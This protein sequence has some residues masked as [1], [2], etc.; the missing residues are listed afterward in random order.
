MSAKLPSADGPWIDGALRW[1]G[2][3]PRAFRALLHAYLLIDFR[4]QQFGRATLSGPKA[5][6]A[7]MFWVVG[8]NLL[9]GFATGVILY[10]RVDVFFFA[11]ANLAVS[12]LVMATAVI[13]EFNEVVLDPEDLEVVGHLPVPARTY[14]AARATNL[15][16]Y[17]LLITVS[18]NLCPAIIGIGLPD[19]GWAFVPAYLLASLA[20][21]LLVVG[22]LI[23][24]YLVLLGD[25]PTESTR[26]LLAWSQIV[27][28]WIA[29]M[30][31]QFVLL[32]DR[33]FRIEML[34]YELPDWVRWLPPGWLAWFVAS[35]GPVGDA[36]AWWVPGV[37]AVATLG[38]WVVVMA[39]LSAAY[40]QMQPGA[41]A[42]RRAVLRPLPRPGDLAGP[43]VRRL[44]RAG[45][46]RVAYWLCTAMLRRDYQL[47][48]RS[49]PAF[50]VALAAVVLGLATGQLG[51]PMKEHS[52][53]CVLSLA[54]LY[55]LTVPVPTILYN[56]NFSR[57]HQASWVLLSAPIGD[58]VAF[59]EGMRKAVTYGVVLPV[60]V[61]LGIVFAVCWRDPLDAAENV[62]AGW[63][64]ILAA[65]HASQIGV[66]RGL[67]F[68]APAA[69]GETMGPIAM[70]A[71]LV[72]GTAMSLVGLH[73]LASQRFWTFAAYLGGLAV[74]VLAL[75][76]AA[77]RVLEQHFVTEAPGHD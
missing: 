71:A 42:W 73:Y 64:A 57:D 1:A 69:R 21:N 20:G 24:V 6:V 68:A 35:T 74:A 77:S 51:D 76:A 13:V 30:G 37:V 39:R 17:V 65:G 56:L 8:Q 61:G 45:E 18:L 44:T 27:L 62:L 49:W 4:N 63:L 26:E 53:V 15:I 47:R 14:S 10:E 2:I 31:G 46:E 11:L 58:R 72:S 54:A 41:P 19:A 67:P 43:I 59:A 9:L 16:G 29:L 33:S 55:L 22:A 25:R 66:L 34:A 52:G 32:H 40:A 60:L 48:M 28:L 75:R 5:W 50:G 12:M 38:V 3:E 7:P 23:L 70:F 36:V